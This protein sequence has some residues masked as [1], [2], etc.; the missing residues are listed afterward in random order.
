MRT[1]KCAGLALSVGFAVWQVVGIAHGRDTQDA[2]DGRYS[3]SKKFLDCSPKILKGD[4]TLTL[5]LGP[6]HG[7]ELAIR[8]LKGDVWYDLVIRGFNG[9]AKLN[10]L[11]T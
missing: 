1:L 8:R 7:S 11:M 9:D 2:E 10:P 3:F 6:G 5:T 4:Q